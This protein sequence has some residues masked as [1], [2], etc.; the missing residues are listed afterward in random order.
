VQ[1][2][3]QDRTEAQCREIIR[4][5]LKNGVLYEAEYDDPV[6]RRKRSGLRLDTTKRPS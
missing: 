2:H 4:I 5:W 6:D 3:C 1:K